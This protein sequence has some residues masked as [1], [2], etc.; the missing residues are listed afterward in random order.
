[1]SRD[2]S[3]GPDGLPEAQGKIGGS[4]ALR[5]GAGQLGA[6]I[7]RDT[8]AVLLPLFLV[9]MLAVPAWLAGLVVLLPKIWLI[10]CDPMMGNWY[11]QAKSRLGRTPF[12]VSGALGTSLGLIAPFII[13]SYPNHW[14]A[15][16]SVCAIFFAGSTAFSLF[17][18]PYLAAASELS[19]DPFERNRIIVMRMIFG[20]IGVLIGVG[21]PQLLVARFGG[22]AAGWHMTI[23]IFAAI[24][25]IS[26]MTT[27]LGLRGAASIA[28]APSPGRLRDQ[29]RAISRNRPFL[30]LLLTSFLSNIGQAASYTVVGFIFL[31]KV[32]AIALIPIYILVMSCSSLLAKPMWLWLPRK[33][34]KQACFTGASLAWI[35][36]TLTWLLLGTF[37]ERT[38]ALPVF[39]AVPVEHAL[40]L[41]RAIVIGVAN[42]GFVLLALS[43]MTDAIDHAR[44]TSGIANEGV[45][46]GVF[47]ALEKFAFAIGPLIAGFVLSGFG[48][49]AS[50]GGAVAQ[51]DSAVFGIVLLYSLIPAGLQ[52][53]ALAVF[54]RYR[55]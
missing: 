41:L 19:G 13:T 1:M 14:I 31:Y 10:F 17:S 5:F 42:G 43:M 15:A 55:L 20:T 47:S 38:I 36:V 33:I 29:M 48:F 4:L 37:G 6:Q 46:S 45:F 27:A 2:A 34:G 39:G 49:V 23:G 28:A 25:L 21:M 11:D 9:T 30:V 32:K 53:L 26:M 8:P 24:C 35:A 18:V 40:I 51:A 54:S 16:A 12:L 52:I 7:F 22:G 50:H 3:Q 44:R